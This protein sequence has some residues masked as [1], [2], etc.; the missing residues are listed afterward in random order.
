MGHPAAVA[1]ASAVRAA[2]IGLYLTLLAGIAMLGL[3]IAT[4]V[5]ALT[6]R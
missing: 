5:P 2:G 1:G 6:K 4:L 3:G